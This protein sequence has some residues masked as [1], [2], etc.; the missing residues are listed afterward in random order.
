M[1]GQELYSDHLSAVHELNSSNFKNSIFINQQFSFAR[2]KIAPAHAR[3]LL[4]MRIS[5]FFTD[6][7][8]LF[9]KFFFC[10]FPINFTFKKHQQQ[11]LD[12]GSINVQDLRKFGIS[13]LLGNS[14]RMANYQNEDELFYNAENR[15]LY[16]STSF[17]VSSVIC[18][19]SCKLQRDSCESTNCFFSLQST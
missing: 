1:M 15:L 10:L 8:S 16:Q 13:K 17:T 6:H 19:T 3:K 4:I 18:L 5:V 2:D 9:F 12:F 11:V 7:V 14:V